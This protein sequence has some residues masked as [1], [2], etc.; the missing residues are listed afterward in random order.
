[1][2]LLS[3]HHEREFASADAHREAV[4]KLRGRLLAIGRDQLGK[5]CEQAG[6]RQAIPVDA[7]DAGLQ[8]SLVQI[9]ER[10]PFLFMLWSFLR[11]LDGRYCHGGCRPRETLAVSLRPI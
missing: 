5:G 11:S 2:S 8:P 9:A 10:R 4:G 3:G 7:V 6:L 1:M